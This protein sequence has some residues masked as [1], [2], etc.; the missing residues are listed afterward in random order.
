MKIVVD[1]DVSKVAEFMLRNVK[2]RNLQR[3]AHALSELSDLV[4]KPEFYEDAPVRRRLFS[5]DSDDDPGLLELRQPP[6]ANGLDEKIP[7]RPS[8]AT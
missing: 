7:I 2:A 8:D 3:V 1:S 4:W 6:S 5:L